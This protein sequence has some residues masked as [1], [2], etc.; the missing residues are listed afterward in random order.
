[1]IK[2]IIKQWDANKHKLEKYFETTKQKDYNSYE[3]IVVKLFELVIEGFDIPKMT[4]INHGTYHGTEI[5]IIPRKV[6]QPDIEDYLITDNYYG[7]C[8]GDDTLLGILDYEEGIP[9]AEQVQEYMTLALHLTQK[10]RWLKE[11]RSENKCRRIIDELNEV[12]SDDELLLYLDYVK[13][14][15]SKMID[16]EKVTD[17]DEIKSKLSVL[18]K[19]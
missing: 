4:V 9:T 18:P 2:P 5:F 6:Y 8:S 14:L 10:M 15:K 13:K 19:E 1:M 12:F 11:S 3:K 17:L 16:N 7:S